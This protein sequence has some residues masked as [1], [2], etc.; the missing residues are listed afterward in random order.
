MKVIKTFWEM[1]RRSFLVGISTTAAAN[2]LILARGAAA[3]GNTLD[4]SDQT[5]S[6][7]QFWML[8]Y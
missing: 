2:G 3:G 7:I 5:Q 8:G 6:G 4:F 1:T